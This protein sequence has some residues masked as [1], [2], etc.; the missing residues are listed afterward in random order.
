MA[1]T[2]LHVNVFGAGAFGGWTALHLLRAGCSVTLIEAWS[3]GHGR[4]SSG[5][6]TRVLRH[7]Y[8]AREHYVPF[9]RRSLALWRALE[10]ER[11]VT[12]FRP[13][14]VLWLLRG[15]AEF[16]RASRA[17]LEREGL[18][19]EDLDQDALAKRF[20]A[21]A[22]DDLDGAL[23]EHEAGALFAR[24]ACEVVHDAVRAAGGDVRRGAASGRLFKSRGDRGGRVDAELTD[25]SRVP[26]DAHVFACGPWLPQLF[27]ELLQPYLAVTRQEVFSFGLP[28]GDRLHAGL[29]VWAEYGSTFWYGIPEGLS[30]GFKIGE[31]TWGPMFDP[32]TGDRTPTSVG[33][34][35]A[36]RYLAR[37]FPALAEAPL[38]DQRVCQY[39]L[40]IDQELLV[41]R[42]PDHDAVWFVGG[43]SGHGFKLGPA[44]GE[45]V[46][47]VVSGGLAPPAGFRADPRTRR[48]KG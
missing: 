2:P 47:E 35:R 41:D 48:A 22:V 39:T 15:A 28:A 31:D 9:V 23:Y 20:P 21:F 43:G 26:G 14:G 36:E 37:R 19:F 42:H 8:G 46:A 45:L 38:V 27:P 18:P 33:R 16:E 4:S 24:R 32:T 13:C 7:A 17:H 10:A 44:V 11:H 40:T 25:G 1:Q 3:A 29:P 30:G 6:D 12:L 5:D 34:E